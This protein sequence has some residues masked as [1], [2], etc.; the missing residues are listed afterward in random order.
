MINS[1]TTAVIVIP[2]I[3][4]KDNESLD[5]GGLLGYGPIMKVSKVKPDVF[6]NRGGQIPAPINSLK[7]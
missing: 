2:A 6:I 7:N 1:K 3:G 4:K 5:F